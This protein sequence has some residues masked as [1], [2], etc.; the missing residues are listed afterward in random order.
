MSFF[1]RVPLAPPDPILGLT[2]AYNADPRREKVNLGVGLYK[3]EDLRTEALS[4]VKDSEHF[5]LGSEKNKEYLPIEGL[6]VFIEKI[7][8]MIF[9][10]SFWKNEKGRIAGCQ[11][12]GGTGALK[13]A[14]TFIKEELP[15]PVLV[16]VPTWP[17]HVGL[18]KACQLTVEC[19]PYYD[20]QKHVVQFDNMVGFL[21]KLSK[22][23]IV[24][25]HACCHN[26]TGIDPSLR[27][28]ELLAD[29][30]QKKKLIP[31]FD[32]AYQGFG[33]GVVED[34]KAIRL[35][36]ERGLE[37]VVAFSA[38]KNFSL[39][40]ERVGALYIVNEHP[41]TAQHVLSRLKQMI[42][43]T[44]SNPPIHGAA[45]VA[46]ILSSAQLSA[47]WQQEL[48]GMR[49][50]I[51]RMRKE[52]AKRLISKV[53]RWDFSHLSRGLGMFCFSGLGK[54][55][56]DRLIAEYGI[57]LPADGRINLCGLNE[58]NLDYVVNA[59]DLL[60]NS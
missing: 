10:E 14:G 43:T 41:Q 9:G 19:Y 45:I 23:S 31:F 38:S 28:W 60:S 53:S 17:N 5:L 47:K 11:T 36:A 1:D 15:H 27:E 25:L 12:V 57:Y 6:G 49:G 52:F 30:F 46:H 3:D 32:C 16:P 35:F 22:G 59:I 50:R 40:G 20:N 18:L 44:Y 56:V 4:C 7:G 58:K 34:V 2:A 13:I 21:E 37:M 39:Y 48:D 42:R 54:E 26:P 8:E 29:M 51:V 33:E 24:V 55:H